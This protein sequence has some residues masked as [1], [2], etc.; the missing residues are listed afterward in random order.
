[1]QDNGGPTLTHALKSG[2]PAID[3]GDDSTAPN[4]DQRGVARPQGSASDIGAFE[5]IPEQPPRTD[6][7]PNSTTTGDAPL[8]VQF[9]D[10]SAGYPT[11][12]LWNFGDGSTSRL[13]N[14]SHTYNRG[15][16]F[17]VILTSTNSFGRDTETKVGLIRVT[18]LMSKIA[19]TSNRDGNSEI[20]LMDADGSNLVR[21]TN[22][23]EEDYDPAW[24]PDGK[25]IAFQARRDDGQGE[26]YVMNQDG[27]EQTR[28]TN[29]ATREEAPSW[30]PDGT[31]IAYASNDIYVMNADGTNTLNVTG[32]S[33]SER[34]PSW[35]PSGEKIAFTKRLAGNWEIFVMDPDGSNQVN[36][37]DNDAPD[38]GS[39]WSPD[40][41]KVIFASG[42]ISV[43]NADG[44]SPMLLTAGSS[45]SPTWSPDGTRIAFMSARQSNS[46]EIYVMNS[47]GSASKNITN[48]PAFD[49]YPA[50]SPE[51][52]PQVPT[53]LQTTT[54]ESNNT[55]TFKWHA[56]PS[57][58]SY[59]MRFDGGAW[60]TIGNTTTFTASSS[61]TVGDHIFG[62]RSIA[63]T[64][65]E[66]SPA[67]LA[68]AVSSPMCRYDFNDSNTTER[69][70]AIA[71]VADYLLQRPGGQTPQVVPTRENAIE[72]VTT[73]LL[74]QIFTC[75]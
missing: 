5:R 60:T 10:T 26:I 38:S 53:D 4:T 9:T 67:R 48:H 56:T 68:F 74:L 44:S 31:R 54:P 69:V 19:F 11:S 8:N 35:S 66:G 41:M 13:R 72:V 34:L 2:S 45:E 1:L 23:P 70:E 7:T 59:E 58:L 71:I 25:L 50:Y 65:F 14:P 73:H 6:F 37:T 57:T 18:G 21:L 30:S 24:S 29:K 27:T 46:W 51:V 39:A 17:T 55:P 47:D 40:G 3:A 15:G 61:M 36:L 49:A 42:G 63:V 12:W 62:V 52:F 28:L 32:T 75:P 33:E 43:M 22:D 64:G 20:Y 16:V